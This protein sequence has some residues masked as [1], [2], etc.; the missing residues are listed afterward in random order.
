MLRKRFTRPLIVSK[1]PV[2]FERR[3]AAPYGR[4]LAQVN[5]SQDYAGIYAPFGQ[6]IAP[7]PNN[8]AVAI[9]LAAIGVLASLSRRH[10]KAGVFDRPRTQQYMPMRLA[11]GFCECRRYREYLRTGLGQ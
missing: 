5:L 4:N 8:E 9:G 2:M 3:Q 10:H 11:R 7:G 6:D 1:G